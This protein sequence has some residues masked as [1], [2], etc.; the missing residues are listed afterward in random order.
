MTDPKRAARFAE[1]SGIRTYHARMEKELPILYTKS[2][3]PW[4]EEA[5]AFL[6]EHGVGYRLKEVTSDRGAYDEMTRKSGQDKAPTLDWNGTILADFGT[7][8]LVPFLQKHG[9]K[10]E[11]S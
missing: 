1:Q 7:D 5:V 8:E 6:D 2:G 9:V 4:C 10:L 3:C 11:E